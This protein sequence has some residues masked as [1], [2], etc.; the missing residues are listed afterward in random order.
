MGDTVYCGANDI[1]LNATKRVVESG[2]YKVPI[3]GLN[4]S[5][6]PKKYNQKNMAIVDAKLCNDMIGKICN[7]ARDFQAYYWHLYNEG[8]EEQKEYLPKIY[9]DLCILEVMSNI[10]IDSAKRRYNVNLASELKRLKERDYLQEN[11]LVV[12]DGALKITRKRYKK[13]FEKK[14]IADYEALL[15]KR[16]NAS[17]EEEINKINEKIDQLLMIEDKYYVRP[18]FTK[19]LSSKSRKVKKKY[20][21]TEEEKKLYEEK[22]AAQTEEEK[23]I[24]ENVY[25]SLNS[26]MDILEKV[27]DKHIIKAP[28]APM[29]QI[30]DILN[31]KPKGQRVDKR[32]VGAIK[33]I[34]LEGIKELNTIQKNYDRGLLNL[35]SM[36]SEKAAV[37]DA[38]IQKMKF[39]RGKP[40]TITVSDIDSVIRDVYDMYPE[41][42]KKGKII[43]GAD[44]KAKMIDKRDRDI[45]DAR[46][47]GLMIQW[48]YSAFPDEFLKAIK[49]K[50]GNVSVVKEYSLHRNDDMESARKAKKIYKL[51]GKYYGIVSA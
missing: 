44:G 31:G 18:S 45:K 42:D 14:A 7:L 40:R 21:P 29:I 26:P 11:G 17:T 19:K 24:K 32:R 16:E 28:K 25:K 15:Q 36:Y 41:K 1:I 20:N 48:L 23:F 43:R 12:K 46:V 8:T 49:Y 4:P 35:E 34:A 10:A 6:D 2:L 37:Q 51:D 27:V 13:S 33:E 9:D 39:N 3:N 38:I 50:N 47:G 30:K 22:K 5:P